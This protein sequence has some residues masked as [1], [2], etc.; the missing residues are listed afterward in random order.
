MTKITWILDFLIIKVILVVVFC[1]TVVVWVDG[2][3]LL[4]SIT[5]CLM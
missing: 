3:G 2:E 4:P 1:A 5:V